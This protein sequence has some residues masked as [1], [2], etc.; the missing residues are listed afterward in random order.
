MNQTRLAAGI[1]GVWAAMMISGCAAG[2]GGS[3]NPPVAATVQALI[4]QPDAYPKYL[5]GVYPK[6]G[7][8]VSLGSAQGWGD[9]SGYYAV[10]H[11]SP[12]GVV[13]AKILEQ[14]LLRP[15]DR[16]NEV[17]N[18]RLTVDGSEIT[19]TP[20]HSMEAEA[21]RIQFDDGKTASG[22]YSDTPCWQAG[23]KAGAHLAEVLVWTST[24]ERFTYRW[25]FSV[26]GP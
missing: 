17:N 13:C 11:G 9:D 15:G 23:V 20:T 19:A 16:L 1:I 26:T 2:A 25:A 12:I 10:L 14:P 3:A 7:I 6:P 8:S 5:G 4:D 24:N 22:V 21:V 18:L